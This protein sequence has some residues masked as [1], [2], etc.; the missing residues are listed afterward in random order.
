MSRMPG[1]H[2]RVAMQLC[3]MVNR[4]GNC[5][6]GV[7]F[8]ADATGLKERS[9]YRALECLESHR[10]IE[11]RTKPGKP[12]LIQLH[13]PT[14]TC[15]EPERREDQAPDNTVRGDRG[16]RPDRGRPQPLTGGDNP[17]SVEEQHVEQRKRTIVNAREKEEE[18]RNPAGARLF[19]ETVER[20]HGWRPRHTEGG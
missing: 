6:P 13:H 8:L 11:R 18:Q 17:V 19:A 16:V 14:R 20:L 7:R 4:A 2:L 10:L 9:V 3:K 12:T 1:A 15:P 5:F